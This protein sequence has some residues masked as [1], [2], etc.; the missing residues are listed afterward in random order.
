MKTEILF[1]IHPVT[2]TLRAGRRTVIEVFIAQTGSSGRFNEVR[3]RARSLNI[4]VQRAKPSWIQSLSGTAAHQGI[5]ARVSPYPFATISEL[6]DGADQRPS[7]ILLLDGILDPHNLGAIIRTALC[8]GVDGI[9]IP[10]DRSAYPT[11]AVSK[12][13]AG[14][15]EHIHLVQVTNLV[16]T[17]RNLK[18]KG[19]WVFGLD[20]NADLSLYASDLTGSVAVVIGGEEKGLRRLVR[21]HCDR[22]I[23]IPQSG[24]IDSLNA[25]VAGAIVLYEAVRQRNI[26]NR[27]RSG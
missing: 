13:S 3:S 21:S 24:P 4:P 20:R 18:Q 5:A 19:F 25:S 14:A 23:T 7:L 9:V 16:R 27:S 2:E 17:I 15:L 22:M 11:P 10:K 1:G 6:M 12:A 8:A 26:E